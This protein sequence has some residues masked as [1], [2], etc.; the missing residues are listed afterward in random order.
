MINCLSL[1][2]SSPLY[3]YTTLFRSGKT[4]KIILESLD[5]LGYEVSDVNYDG[6]QD[7]KII[8]AKNFVPQ[9]RE[10]IVLVGFRRDLN[11]HE[12]FTLKDI[13]KHFPEKVATFGEIL[14][15]EQ[16]V[17]IGREHV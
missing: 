6:K 8:D 15:P 17:E 11:V 10:R 12:G 3:P 9:H 2:I 1:Y 4:F 13:R 14:E 7:P 5:E 16:E